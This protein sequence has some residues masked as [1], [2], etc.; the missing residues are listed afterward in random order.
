MY[1]YLDE[2]N[3]SLNALSVKRKDTNKSLFLAD[4]TILEYNVHKGNEQ[5]GKN[6]V[7]FR[8]ACM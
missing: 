1:L 6:K 2:I 5:C 3:I 8:H 7:D 4:L